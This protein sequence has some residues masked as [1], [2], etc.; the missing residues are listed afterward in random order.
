M[1]K[2]PWECHDLTVTLRCTV[3]R[4]QLR[5]WGNCLF[6]RQLHK[7]NAGV[8]INV[9]SI[10][11]DNFQ[12]LFNVFLIWLTKV[13][14]LL[15]FEKWR[16]WQRKVTS[17]SEVLTAC[18]Y[19]YCTCMNVYSMRTV[20]VWVCERECVFVIRDEGVSVLVLRMCS[21]TWMYTWMC[22]CRFFCSWR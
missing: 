3:Y 21:C 4:T 5:A 13:Q 16:R 9:P 12:I 6:Q 18:L 14:Y 17:R 20:C 11:L 1:W 15:T 10:G 2:A 8:I 22:M 19:L 7:C